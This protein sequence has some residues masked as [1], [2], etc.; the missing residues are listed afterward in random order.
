MLYTIPDYYKEFKCTADKCKDTCCAGWQIVI[1]EKSLA[2]YKKVCASRL[3]QMRKN[4]G[5]ESEFAWK[6][7]RSIDWKS[8][9][10]CQSTDC[11]TNHT[12]ELDFSYPTGSKRCAFLDENNLCDLYK[13]LGEKSLCKTCKLYP[14]HIEEFEGL[15]EISL[16]VSCPEVARILMEKRETVKF[17]TYEKEGEEEFEDFDPFLFSILEDARKEMLQILQNRTLPI[18][19]RT[20]L[21]LGMAHDMQVRI[22]RQEMFACS[23]V[24]E[25]YKKESAIEYVRSF[26]A[27]KMGIDKKNFMKKRAVL[28]RELFEKLFELEVL[29]D[30]WNEILQETKDALFLS[31]NNFD[32]SEW[33][34]KHPDVEIHLEQILVYFLFTYFPGAVYDGEV[35]AKVQMSVYCTW[36]IENLWM[37]RWI[38]NGKRLDVEEMTELLYRFS[39]EVEHSDENLKQVEKWMEKKWFLR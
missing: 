19:E 3:L 2:K 24:I 13:N 38:R 31:K 5:G 33:K 21:V 39:R 25:K 30:D 15:R 20:L 9:T 35:Y 28:N 4:A 14:R 26:S 37:A 12:S 22:N 11:N 1:D 17:L 23:D 6:M 36:M 34:A 8:G 10:F 7:I 32:F 18:R 16:S 27:G 29:R